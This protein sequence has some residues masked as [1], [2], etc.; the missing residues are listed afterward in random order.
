M[1][2]LIVHTGAT[3]INDDED[4]WT[5]V[6]RHRRTWFLSNTCNS[7]RKSQLHTA[8]PVD[9]PPPHYTCCFTVFSLYFC[10][11]HDQYGL[12]NSASS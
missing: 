4:G 3:A 12:I 7:N 8:E 6:K 10:G 2:R 5:V 9:S 1:S 11:K